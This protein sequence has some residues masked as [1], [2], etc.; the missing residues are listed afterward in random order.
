MA[1]NVTRY[2]LNPFVCLFV[3]TVITDSRA[4]K[5]YRKVRRILSLLSDIRENS[6]VHSSAVFVAVGIEVLEY[7]RD[8][9]FSIRW[10]VVSKNILVLCPFGVPG[11]RL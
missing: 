6:R 1:V 4:M 3:C 2:Y 11:I 8:T 7:S 5:K 9:D 10:R